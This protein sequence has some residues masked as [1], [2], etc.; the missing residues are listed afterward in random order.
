MFRLNEASLEEANKKA[1]QRAPYRRDTQTSS[2]RISL[3]KNQVRKLNASDLKSTNQAKSFIDCQ[4]REEK[5]SEKQPEENYSFLR[6][7][8]PRGLSTKADSPLSRY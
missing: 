3:M 5:V 7:L 1:P 2:D 6:G 8:L 4:K